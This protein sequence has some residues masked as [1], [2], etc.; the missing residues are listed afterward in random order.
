[1]SAAARTAAGAAAG[2]AVASAAVTAYW[3]AGG[4]ALLDTVGGTFQSLAEA[5]SAPALL[6]GTGVVAAKLVAAV[7]ALAL[8]RR[9]PR[10]MRLLALL[11]GVLLTLWGAANVLLGGAVVPR[12]TSTGSTSSR[13]PG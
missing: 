6:L 9:A 11:A 13:R 10:G 4:T 2:L 7:L 12:S 5:R 1:V 8:L 3:T